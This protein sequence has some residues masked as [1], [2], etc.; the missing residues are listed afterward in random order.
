MIFSIGI[1]LIETFVPSPSF[2]PWQTTY[3]LNFFL[4]YQ[5][6]PAPLFAIYISIRFFYTWTIIIHIEILMKHIAIQT[7]IR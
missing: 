3:N 7:S 1:P 6:H 2:Q 5:G 4:Q